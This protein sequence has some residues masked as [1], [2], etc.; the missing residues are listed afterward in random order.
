MSAITNFIFVPLSF[1]SGTF[2]SI[3]RLE[4]SIHTF[5]QFSPFFYIIDGF[6]Y[7]FLGQSYSNVHLGLVILIICN[8][9]LIG[10]CYFLF[11]K[12]YK[13]KF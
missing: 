1:L 7:G 3:N 5:S 10:L 13:I 8:M 9:I 12:G 2:F 4:G 11:K 6:R